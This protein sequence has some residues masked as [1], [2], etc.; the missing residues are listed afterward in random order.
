MN[1]RRG[2]PPVEHVILGYSGGK[3]SLVML[4][5]AIEAGLQVQPFFKYFIPNMDYTARRSVRT[6]YSRSRF[7]IFRP[8]EKK[9]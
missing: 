8:S 6:T 5:L 1:F 2:F 3:D 4:D 7:S 9:S